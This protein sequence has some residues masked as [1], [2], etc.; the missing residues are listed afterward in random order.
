LFSVSATFEYVFRDR[1]Q[2]DGEESVHRMRCDEG[3]TVQVCLDSFQTQF[4]FE[5]E[6]YDANDEVIPHDKTLHAAAPGRELSY[7]KLDPEFE[8]HV[9]G[10]PPQ[11][12]RFPENLTFQEL[13]QDARWR[14][15]DGAVGWFY[16]GARSE[17]APTDQLSDFQD[18]PILFF[19]RYQFCS[20]FWRKP[21]HG[22]FPPDALLRDVCAEIADTAKLTV[23]DGDEPIDLGVAIETLDS[24]KQFTIVFA[25][26][27]T[28]RLAETATEEKYTFREKATVAS[29]RSWALKRWPQV[30]GDVAIELDGTACADDK[31]F[32]Y[33]TLKGDAVVVR[34]KATRRC[35]IIL[36]EESEPKGKDIGTSWTVAKVIEACIGKRLMAL[37]ECADEDEKVLTRKS[38]FVKVVPRDGTAVIQHRPYIVTFAGDPPK[39][40]RLNRGATVGVL[41]QTAF[42]AFFRDS[43]ADPPI[44][45]DQVTL[46][47]AGSTYGEDDDETLLGDNEAFL[48]AN[49]VLVARK[50]NFH[51][52]DP[53]IG[54]VTLRFEDETLISV[55]IRQLEDRYGE[56][57]ILRADRAP[58]TEADRIL[59][60][61]VRKFEVELRKPDYYFLL[62][63]AD[64]PVRL[65]LSRDDT[66]SA[67]LQRLRQRA[68][69]VFEFDDPASEGGFPAGAFELTRT[70]GGAP[71]QPSDTFAAEDADTPGCPFV[72]TRKPIPYTGAQP[73][74]LM[75]SGRSAGPH[76]ASEN[77][78]ASTRRAGGRGRRPL[79]GVNRRG[80]PLT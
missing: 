63:D 26:P 59:S 6:F 67:V 22:C 40:F 78:W 30:L 25:R 27:L 42:A 9:P 60:L 19:H 33:P 47:A 31:A 72:F 76:F 37:F 73:P 45:L 11:R 17:I 13:S 46:E 79:A 5:C 62:P 68:N 65:T 1:S 20:A 66:A 56:R 43:R 28:V 3:A 54:T 23:Q 24:A 61:K 39:S 77:T 75:E 36:P 16:R 29:V 21:R 55:V 32:L 15:V 80:Y 38:V 74:I 52:R 53:A 35:S 4:K 69:G 10:R 34:E 7:R 41:R 51:F 12:L 44:D 8:F 14:K 70:R 2:P 64:A 57:V 50:Y 71:L 48:N 49:L 18:V 58:F